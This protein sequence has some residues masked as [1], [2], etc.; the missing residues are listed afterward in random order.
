M[1]A[2]MEALAAARVESARPQIPRFDPQWGIDVARLAKIYTG[3]VGGSQELEHPLGYDPALWFS[4]VPEGTTRGWR[5]IP[6]RRRFLLIQWM[7]WLLTL[8]HY[9]RS[10]I[11]SYI[12]ISS[13]SSHARYK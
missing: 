7:L 2:S 12:G 6:Y 3:E 5:S 4:I 13:S 1:R 10:S 11:L 9:N 8:L